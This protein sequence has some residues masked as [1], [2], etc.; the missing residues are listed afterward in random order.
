VQAAAAAGESWEDRHNVVGCHVPVLPA[1]P[2]E[3]PRPPAPP[4]PP[5]WLCAALLCRC[6]SLRA[7]PAC[8][9]RAGQSGGSCRML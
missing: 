6:V 3:L 7:A 9:R 1:L 5:A 8:L 4:A 2:I